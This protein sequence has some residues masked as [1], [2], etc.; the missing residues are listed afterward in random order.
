MTTIS[1]N[2]TAPSTQLL[3]RSKVNNPE[4]DL[5]APNYKP[6][7]QVEETEKLIEN[8]ET[9]Y[10]FCLPRSFSPTCILSTIFCN[11]CYFRVN[12]LSRRKV[13][14]ILTFA[15]TF[16]VLVN[17]YI[18]QPLTTSFTK[19]H[20]FTQAKKQSYGLFDDVPH[21]NWKTMQAHVYEQRKK[22]GGGKMGM[23][24]KLKKIIGL[25]NPEG[26]VITVDPSHY[27]EASQFYQNH[28][29]ADFICPH[30]ERVGYDDVR[31]KYVCNPRRIGSASHDR[32][33]RQG[34]S[35]CIIYTSTANVNEFSFEKALL[36]VIKQGNNHVSCEVHVFSP[37]KHFDDESLPKGVEFHP[38]GFG[39][40]S[41]TK[42]DSDEV[43]FKTIHDT[44]QML[45][46]CGKAID[47]LSIDCEG[48]EFD[49]YNDLFLDS[50]TAACPKASFMQVLVQVHG[51]PSDKTNTFF[52]SFLENNYVVFHKESTSDSKGNEQDYGFL[53]LS[54]DFFI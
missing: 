10:C 40:S 16:C 7:Y 21:T 35:E 47:I 34:E 9:K 20:S 50:N 37:N 18:L 46:H 28:W 6:R 4:E 33:N 8:S 15:S 2:S 44:L 23:I 30:E 14:Y 11:C 1:A 54:S 25:R 13:L 43:E 36:D 26:Q 29:H 45:G 49:I 5:V 22:Q 32:Q 38:W 53:K 39:A 48:C 24:G 31:A 51:A 12:R 17:M 27:K 19:I 41:N 52:N 42:T 3:N